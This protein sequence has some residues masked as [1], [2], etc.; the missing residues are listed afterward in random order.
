MDQVGI[1]QNLCKQ[2][3]LLEV[4]LLASTLSINVRDGTKPAANSRCCINCN[5][6]IPCPFTVLLFPSH[7][8]CVVIAFNDLGAQDVVCRSYVEAILFVELCLLSWNLAGIPGEPLRANLSLGRSISRAATVHEGQAEINIILPFQDRS[9]KKEVATIETGQMP[10]IFLQV[11]SIV[12]SN[13]GKVWS[14]LW[15]GCKVLDGGV[16]GKNPATFVR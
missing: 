8:V 9:A 16:G 13:E 2:E 12:V 15:V 11:G 14:G 3:T 1:F 6:S 7:L 5:E 4:R 10:R